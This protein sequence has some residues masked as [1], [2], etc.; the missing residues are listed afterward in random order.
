M[1]HTRVF[2]R[3]ARFRTDR[4]RRDKWRTKWRTCSSF[5]FISRGLL[6]KNSSWQAKQSIPHTAA[7]LLGDCTKMCE[8]FSLNFDN[9]RASWC[10]TAT[11]RLT[12]PFFI[13]EFLTKN[14]MTLVPYTPYFFVSPIENITE[15][16]PL[17]LNW[18]DRGRIADGPKHHHTG[19]DFQDAFKK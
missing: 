14:K 15:R 6:T 17:W 9:K 5:S 19:Y 10:I 8:D 11:H 16:P 12:H 1:S 3:Q 13:R 4:K 2:E 7:M 18:G